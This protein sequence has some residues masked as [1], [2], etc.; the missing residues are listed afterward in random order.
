MIRFLN[1]FSALLLIIYLVTAEIQ[2]TGAKERAY[3]L[4]HL[5]C[6]IEDLS[7][8]LRAYVNARHVVWV[9]LVLELRT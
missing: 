4:N 9:S 3:L 1:F 5:P 2:Y 6:K 7:S 8:I